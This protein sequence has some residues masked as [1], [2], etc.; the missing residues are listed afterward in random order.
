MIVSVLRDL[1][2]ALA[3]DEIHDPHG[4]SNSVYDGI[5]K[6]VRVMLGER[7]ADVLNNAIRA[8]EDRYFLPEDTG[9]TVW[10]AICEAAKKG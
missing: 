9:P 10:E 4:V 2:V 5:Y 8:Q 3:M 1:V 6:L 7:A